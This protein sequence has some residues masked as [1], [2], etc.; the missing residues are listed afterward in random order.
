VENRG[1][2]YRL[3]EAV[4]ARYIAASRVLEPAAWAA[5]PLRQRVVQN[6]AR[7]ADSLL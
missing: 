6:P 7:L 4:Q 5:R 3:L 2:V 1:R